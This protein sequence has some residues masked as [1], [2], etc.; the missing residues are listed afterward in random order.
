MT[1]RPHP[2]G[3]PRPDRRHAQRRGAGRPAPPPAGDGPAAGP[4]P[5]RGV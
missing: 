2:G 1:R 3:P 4:T 5:A